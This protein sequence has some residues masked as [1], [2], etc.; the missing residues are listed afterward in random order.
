MVENA[1]GLQYKPVYVFTD[2]SCDPDQTSPL[3]TRAAYGAIMYDAEDCFTDISGQNISEDRMDL[4]S[5]D[6]SKKQVV[7]HAELIICHASQQVWKDR[8][9]HEKSGPLHRHHK[10]YQP[11]RR[12]RLAHQRV[13]GRRSKTKPF[14][15]SKLYL[16]PTT[17]VF[18]VVPKGLVPPWEQ[19]R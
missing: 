13:L 2:G 14:R 18:C 1:H 11:H 9:H 12:Q 5:F 17:Q 8:S 7:G 15:G 3:G 16:P 4:I 6:G 19:M 10:R